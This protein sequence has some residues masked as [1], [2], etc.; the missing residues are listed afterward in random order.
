MLLVFPSQCSFARRRT[1]R[2]M[3]ALVCILALATAMVQVARSPTR[4]RSHDYRIDSTLHFLN[5]LRSRGKVPDRLRPVVCSDVLEVSIRFEQ[6]ARP[7]ASTLAHLGR[8]YVSEGNFEAAI[9]CYRQ[10]LAR[11]YAQVQLRL[12]LAK[13][14]VQ[15]DKIS[16]AMAEAK[17]CLQLNPQLRSAKALLEDLSVHP[18]FLA[19]QATSP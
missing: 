11:K 12:E 9:K 6:N 18:A 1:L 7:S 3:T 16:E 8:I 14:L 2:R 19:E 5:A 13:L 17:I 15:T 10:A 4:A